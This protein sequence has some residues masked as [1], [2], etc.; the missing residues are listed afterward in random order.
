MPYIGTQPL[1]GQFKKLD[2]ISV[3]NG[4]PNYTLNYNGAAYKPATANALLVSV[5]GVIQAAG[6]AFNIS[7]STITFTENLVTGDV[8]D[9]IIALGDTG[10]A[11]TPVDGSVTTAK[12]GDDSVTEA[13]LANSLDMQNIT[14]KGGTTDALTIGSTGLVKAHTCAF[15]IYQN[16]AQSLSNGVVT[17][18]NFTHTAIDSDSLVDLSNNKVVITAATAGLWYLDVTWRIENTV[19]FR[20]AAYIEINGVRKSSFEQANYSQTTQ[21]YQSHNS[22]LI[23]DLSSGD[24]VTFHAYQAYG[25]ARNTED[26]E[27]NVFA[28]GYRIG[29][30]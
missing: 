15:R 22:H 26:G 28:Q 19:P 3:V 14:L 12:L 4:Q 17:V 16:T 11:V 7:G 10:S 9:F 27:S 5:N 20:G 21:A 1:T 30:I 25:S 2:A 6:D 23:A 18:L 8:I 29:M 13:K 24:E